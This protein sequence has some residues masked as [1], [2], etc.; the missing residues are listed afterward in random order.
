[1]SSKITTFNE[2]VQYPEHENGLGDERRLAQLGHKEALRRS[3]SLHTLGALCI[4]LMA[5]WEAL[6]TVIATALQSGGPPCLF[7]N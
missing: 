4:C 7:Y 3:F 5:T 6:S 2:H 1:M